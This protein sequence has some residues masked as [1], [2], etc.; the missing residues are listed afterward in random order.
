MKLIG[1]QYVANGILDFIKEKSRTSPQKWGF[2]LCSVMK[3]ETR[4]NIHDAV[5]VISDNQVKEGYI[6]EIAFKCKSVVGESEIIYSVAVGPST[7]CTRTEG[8]VF[9]SKEELLK[10]L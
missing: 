10:S 2:L 8:H 5:W 9:A 4:F 7:S 3:V 1:V 6:N